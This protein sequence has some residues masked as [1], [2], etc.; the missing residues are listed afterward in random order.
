[1]C[2][3]QYSYQ[4]SDLL[5]GRL[6]AP[7]LPNATYLVSVLSGWFVT[8]TVQRAVWERG[9]KISPDVHETVW[10]VDAWNSTFRTWPLAAGAEMPTQWT[11]LGDL[12]GAETQY[13]LTDER[14]G[15][16][17]ADFR[18]SALH[19]VAAPWADC[20]MVR[21]ASIDGHVGFGYR[22]LPLDTQVTVRSACMAPRFTRTDR[23]DDYPFRTG[24]HSAQLCGDLVLGVAHV[25]RGLRSLARGSAA[26]DTVRVCTP[27]QRRLYMP[28]GLA[29]VRAGSRRLWDA[30]TSELQ[31]TPV[32][33]AGVMGC[34]ALMA[35]SFWA[36]VR[37]G[38]EQRRHRRAHVETPHP[39]DD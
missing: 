37:A 34:V 7:L 13:T 28:C 24:V 5:V 12:S 3:D 18:V 8:R 10:A 17:S 32:E 9:R 36:S 16:G 21:L 33:W 6:L 23:G 38:M 26:L 31:W 4:C 27:P 20:C 11:P 14:G 1:V 30:A 39:R 2:T 19:P 35:V 22:P 29:D 15:T 25:D